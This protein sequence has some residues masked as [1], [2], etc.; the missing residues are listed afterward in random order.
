MCRRRLSWFDGACFGVPDRVERATRIGNSGRD[1]R[2][3]ALMR[4]R[5]HLVSLH[6]LRVC[7]HV[8]RQTTAEQRLSH[9]VP[10]PTP[11]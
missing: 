5:E 2:N 9:H 3:P 7:G 10:A 6:E 11:K 1:Q 8:R 4:A